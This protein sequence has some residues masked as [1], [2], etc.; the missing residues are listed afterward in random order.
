MQTQSPRVSATDDRLGTVLGVALTLVMMVAYFG[1]IGL[2]SFAPA[3]LA[4]PVV[5]GGTVTVAFAYGLFVIG[6]GVVLTSAYVWVTSRR[7]G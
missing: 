6:L 5:A 2:G 1:F 3:V 7:A 4:R